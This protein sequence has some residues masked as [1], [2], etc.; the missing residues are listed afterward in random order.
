MLDY[1]LNLQRNNKSN[2]LETIKKNSKKGG[3]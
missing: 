3:K 2:G 1:G